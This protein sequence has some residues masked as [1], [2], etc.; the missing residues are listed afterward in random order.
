MTLRHPVFLVFVGGMLG[1]GVRLA[2]DAAVP[3]LGALPW[4]LVVINVV[5][6]AALGAIDG[7]IAVRGAR[8]WW[9]LVGTGML[10]GFT[11]FSSIAAL[12]WTSDAGPTASLALLIATMTVAVVAAV[13][14]RRWAVARAKAPA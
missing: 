11:T 9:P 14:G 4:D 8:W 13:A 2:L 3:P 6:S 10:G 5:G 7:Y 1:G 12:E